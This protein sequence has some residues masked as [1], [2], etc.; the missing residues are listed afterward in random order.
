MIRKIMD[1]VYL[2]GVV[3]IWSVNLSHGFVQFEATKSERRK[4][5]ASVDTIKTKYV[6]EDVREVV[7][8]SPA[9]DSMLRLFPNLKI[10]QKLPAAE[11]PVVNA[12]HLLTEDE[13]ITEA[14]P[15][16]SKTSATENMEIPTIYDFLFHDAPIPNYHEEK[17]SNMWKQIKRHGSLK[18]VNSERIILSLRVAYVCLWGLQ[19]RNSLESSIDR[20]VGIAKVLG[21]L[22]TTMGG[23]AEFEEVI[24][25]GI[26]HDVLHVL[27]H[28]HTSRSKK[29]IGKM[30]MLFGMNAVKL[31]D[32]YNRLP[33]FIP[34]SFEY[35][36]DQ[37]DHF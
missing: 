14:Q 22:N 34:K 37:G 11:I 9:G 16:G 12:W 1:L 28:S 24:L 33:V 10:H 29:I 4:P 23:R 20:A 25:A 3:L 13:V 21:E 31:A 35:S 7:S 15:S 36:L 26:I 19:Y 30:I 8:T 18:N 17:I 6:T 27:S 5:F 2:L 32:E